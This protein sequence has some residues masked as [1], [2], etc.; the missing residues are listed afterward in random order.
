MLFIIDDNN[1]ALH[2]NE[3]I[4]QLAPSLHPPYPHSGETTHH[5]MA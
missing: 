4:L 5:I 3:A 2:F 1:K